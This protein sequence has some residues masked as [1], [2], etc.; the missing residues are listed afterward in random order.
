MLVLRGVVAY[1]EPRLRRTYGDDYRRYCRIVPRWWPA[2]SRLPADCEH[3]LTGEA[4]LAE[5]MVPLVCVPLFIRA[6]FL[7]YL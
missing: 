2:R 4:I 1:E 3:R 6:V 7:G 5:S